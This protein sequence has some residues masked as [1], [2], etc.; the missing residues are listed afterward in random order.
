[1][2]AAGSGLFGSEVGLAPRAASAGSAVPA[3]PAFRFARKIVTVGVRH[4]H[5]ADIL[6]VLD[7][8]DQT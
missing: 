7:L 5:Q 2:H 3:Q 6:P 4:R 1:M 8:R